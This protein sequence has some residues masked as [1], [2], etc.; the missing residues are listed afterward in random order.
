MS[1]AAVIEKRPSI[2]PHLRRLDVV[3]LDSNAVL[4][5]LFLDRRIA[6]L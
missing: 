3:P 6:Y 5:D 1:C 2:A 4:F